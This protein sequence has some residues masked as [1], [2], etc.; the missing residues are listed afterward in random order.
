M[1]IAES[2]EAEQRLVVGAGETTTSSACSGSLKCETN[3]PV[4]AGRTVSPFTLNATEI[5]SR[6]RFHEMRI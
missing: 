4:A 2:H 3:V 6:F 1:L 5:R